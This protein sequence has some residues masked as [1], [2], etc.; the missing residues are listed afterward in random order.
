M[1]QEKP[2]GVSVLDKYRERAAARKGRQSIDV[3][4]ATAPGAGRDDVGPSHKSKKRLRDGGN[5]STTHRSPG[6]LPTSPPRREVAE[7]VPLSPWRVEQASGHRPSSS[8]LDLLEGNHRFMRRVRVALLEGTRESLRSVAPMDLVRSGLE[9]MCRS[10]VLVEHGIEGHDRHAE[11]ISRMEQEL[12]EA[13]ENLKRSLAANDDFSASVAR[14][15]AERELA[16]KDAAEAR[17]LL[18]SAKEEAL[19]TAAEV[20]EVKKTAEEKLSSSAAELAVLQTAKEQVEAELDQN[21]EESGELLKQCFD[22]AVRQT[23]VLYGGPPAVGELNMDYEVHQGRLVPS[24]EV[25]V[26]A[27]QEALAAGAHEEEVEA[28][29]GECVEIQD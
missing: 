16:K 13:R 25:G 1:V 9:L 15:A 28:E 29:E 21:Y 10:I 2:T 17:R 22:R 14:E 7:A 5:I 24:A 8:A 4:P 27:A 26:L 18:V 20:V 12:S 23:H 6:S 11:E 19:R 3:L